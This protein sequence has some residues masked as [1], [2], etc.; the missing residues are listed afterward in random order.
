MKTVIVIPAFNEAETIADVVRA[1]LR[2]ADAV[3]V[4]DD[5]SR[6][7][8]SAHA[9][10]AGAHVVRHSVNGGYDASINDGFAAAAALG[11]DVI[12]TC[13]ADGQHKA[14]DIPRLVEPIEHDIAD[15]VL[16][17][18]PPRARPFGERVFAAYT[19]MRFGIPDP[20]S[21]LK[22][23]RRE[24]YDRLG[25]FDTL[26]SIGTQLSLEAVQLGYRIT[27]VPIEIAPR[28]DTSRFYARR[29]RANLR[30]LS[31]MGR[32]MHHRPPQGDTHA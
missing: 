7:E 19:K 17:Q 5:C 11:A 31:A 27:L 26:T 12:V 28:R 3:V 21:G 14:A 6:D 20:L 13:D 32:I 29:L 2:V 10:D 16:S 8:T 18:R 30:I 25:H 23:Y 1:V 22:A 4:V 9:R 24:V 15:V